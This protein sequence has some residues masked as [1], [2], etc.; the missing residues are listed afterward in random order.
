MSKIRGMLVDNTM[1]KPYSHSIP[2]TPVVTP[3]AVSIGFEYNINSN[4]LTL[5]DFSNALPIQVV[6]DSRNDTVSVTPSTNGY[7]Q[8][9]YDGFLY[10]DRPF[11]W[12]LDSNPSYWGNCF[13]STGNEL[14]L[15]F[16]G[17][18]PNT[19]Y[20]IEAQSYRKSSSDRFTELLDSNDA[21]NIT[22]INSSTEPPKAPATI[23]VVTDGAGNLSLTIRPAVG[24]SYGYITAMRLVPA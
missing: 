12:T 9:L 14:R 11:D 1:P 3:D 20:E 7:V 23:Q 6:T 2:P 24:T 19:N 16:E 22:S 15:A 4:N 5:L 8:S 13:V 10:E 17:L 18:K 21:A